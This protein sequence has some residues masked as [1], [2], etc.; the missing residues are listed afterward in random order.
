MKK[1]LTLLLF[2]YNLDAGLLQDA[3]DKAPSG[4]TLKLYSGVYSD[5]I[6]IV[7][8][9]TIIGVEDGVVI[10]GGGVG[11]VISIKSSNVTLSNLTIQNSGSLM[12]SLDSGIKVEKAKNIHI[13]KCKILDSLYGID[14]YM[15]QDSS[16][17]E[18]FIHSKDIE[19]SLR[20]DALKIWHSHNNLISK[21]TITNSRDITLNYS[22][23]NI[24]EDNNISNSRFALK[25]A[26]SKNTLIKKNSFRYNSVSLIMM[27][28]EHSKI[29]N[30]SILSSNGAAGIGVMLQ[31]GSTIFDSNRLRYNAKGIYIDSNPNEKEMKRYITNNDIS[32][33]KEAIGFHMTIRQ[34]TIT[35][36]IFEGN[37]DDIVKGTAGYKTMLNRVEY[38]YWDRYAGFD[39]DGDNIGDNSFLIYQYADRLWHYNNKV[40][41][42]YGSPIMSMLNFLAQVAPFIE[43]NL[44]LEDSKPLVERLK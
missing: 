33:N 44:L 29:I 34:N 39:T 17:K 10:D 13:T 18:N 2:I 15:V 8:P 26:H 40:K 11:N 16:I 36:N 19:I 6:I 12:H 42:F 32:Y 25:V 5:N 3:I 21:N 41:F 24:I 4:S 23:D 31:G 28:S 20:G 14:M 9:L 1:L 38:N 27:M 22:H 37:I 35:N 30:N 43:P 7:K